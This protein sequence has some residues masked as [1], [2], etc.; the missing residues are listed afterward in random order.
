MR[1]RAG[2]GEGQA[3]SDKY[4]IFCYSDSM[5]Q[6]IS[7]VFLTVGIALPMFA[8]NAD[9]KWPDCYCTDKSGSRVELGETI[10]MYVD[11]R[12][13]TA[14]CEMSLNN[15]MWRETG[16]SCLSSRSRLPQGSSPIDYAGLVHS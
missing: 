14:R 16:D 9:V 1:N 5:R 2:I 8:E 11:G 4:R 6:L 15:P 12:S 3:V 13:F 10:C 7:S